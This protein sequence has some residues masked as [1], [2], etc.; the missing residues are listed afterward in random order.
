M[1]LSHLV[2]SKAENLDL[3]EL[4]H[5]HRDVCRISFEADEDY[6]PFLGILTE[7]SLQ[8]RLDHYPHT[9][10][11]LYGET[12]L[13]HQQ[14]NVD[15]YISKKPEFLDEIQ[16]AIVTR[17]HQ[18]IGKLFGY[19]ECCIESFQRNLT[20][21]TCEMPLLSSAVE[22]AIRTQNFNYPKIMSPQ[23]PGNTLSF[24]PCSFDCPSALKKASWRADQRLRVFSDEITE[25]VLRIRNIVITFD[26]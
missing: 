3:I 1:N 16:S 10:S 11:G 14:D 23:I 12:A 21:P 24:F 17:Q 7:S 13:R 26:R 19:P 8:F 4:I 15:V 9:A 22:T 25:S 6:R 5:G 2:F 20:N 18:I